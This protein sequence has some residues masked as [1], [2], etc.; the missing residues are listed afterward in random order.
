MDG[1]LMGDDLLH[2]SITGFPGMATNSFRISY[3]GKKLLT[4][5]R[6]HPLLLRR[7]KKARI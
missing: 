6:R 2:I 7:G 3:G 4:R 5:G 1:F